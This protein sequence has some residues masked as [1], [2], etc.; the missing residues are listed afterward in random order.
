MTFNQSSI[1]RAAR[2]EVK[3]A[4]GSWF[5]HLGWQQILLSL[6]SRWWFQRIGKKNKEKLAEHRFTH[7]QWPT[8]QVQNMGH[9]GTQT[10]AQCHALQHIQPQVTL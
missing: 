1:F 4:S 3:C 10:V 6:L 8:T 2:H 9:N 5:D 7:Q